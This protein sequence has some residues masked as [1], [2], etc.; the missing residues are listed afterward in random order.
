MFEEYFPAPIP[1][2]RKLEYEGHFLERFRIVPGN[3]GRAFLYCHDSS[4]GELLECP[5]ED[6]LNKPGSNVDF[7]TKLLYQWE[8][9]YFLPDEAEELESDVVRYCNT[10]EYPDYESREKEEEEGE[11]LSPCFFDSI[12]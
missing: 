11:S 1:K 9:A 7:I 4:T 5:L 10:G 12:F 3:C 8:G 2:R 6:I